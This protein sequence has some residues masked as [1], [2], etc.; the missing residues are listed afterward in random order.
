[1]SITY[2]G[3]YTKV[4]RLV[5]I[6]FKASNTTGDIQVSSYVTFSGVPF[7]INETCTSTVVTEDIDQF[8]RQGFAGAAGTTISLSACGSATGTTTLFAS[9][10]AYI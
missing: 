10:V 6:H 1:M 2:S 7:T 3:T 9:I 4:G 5:H 8:S